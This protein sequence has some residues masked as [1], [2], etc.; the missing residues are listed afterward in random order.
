MTELK[1]NQNHAF[2]NF[3]QRSDV[4]NIY[5]KQYIIFEE[6]NRSLTTNLANQTL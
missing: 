5:V 1:K 3:R 6:S 4:T 2:T